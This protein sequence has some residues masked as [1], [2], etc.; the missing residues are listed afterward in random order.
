MAGGDAE[1]LA[2]KAVESFPPDVIGLSVRNIDDQNRTGRFLLEDVRRMVRTCREL[3]AAPICLGGAGYSIFP[4][5]ALAYLEA[6][7]GIRG[8]G[9]VAFPLLLARLERGADLSGTPGLYLRNRG[10]QGERLF[11]EDLDALPLSGAHDFLAAPNGE[12]MLPFQTRR[13]CPMDCSYCSTAA[14]EGRMIRKKSPEAAVAELAR[15]VEAGF[16]RIYFADNTFNIPAG[17]AK[18][19]CRGMIA[20][21]LDI[22]WQCILYPGRID[23]ELVALMADAG[24][25]EVSLGFESGSEKILGLMNKRFTPR[26]VRQTAQLF[27]RYGIRQLGFLMLGGPGETRQSAGESLAFADSL[28]LDQLKVTTG[29]RIYPETALAGTAVADGIIAPDDDLLR[30][31]FYLVPELQEWLPETVK[32]WMAERPHWMS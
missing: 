18:A 22:S 13:G 11:A 10:L 5:G 1:F 9:E 20:R 21:G 4:E 8:E 27:K 3:S 29:I 23:E 7:M 15:C 25:R 17:Y 14:I 26:E 19:L 2:R 28:P 16:T 32:R 30:P 31:Q 24:C 6:D 12:F